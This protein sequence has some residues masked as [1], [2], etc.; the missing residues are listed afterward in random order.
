[1]DLAHRVAGK[2]TVQYS[3]STKGG[4]PEIKDFILRFRTALQTDDSGEIEPLPP[5][6]FVPS[7]VPSVYIDT[8]QRRRGVSAL[9][10]SGRAQPVTALGQTLQRDGDVASNNHN[11]SKLAKAQLIQRRDINK[12]RKNWSM[13][14]L[15]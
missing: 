3:N 4:R 10:G 9:H 6:L 15:E 12:A 2:N 14:P 8:E 5:S 7:P 13:M 1:M 11:C